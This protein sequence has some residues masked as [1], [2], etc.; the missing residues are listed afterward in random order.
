[1]GKKSK[2]ILHVPIDNFKLHQAM[3]ETCRAC[4]RTHPSDRILFH[5]FQN[6]ARTYFELTSIQLHEYETSDLLKLCHDCVDKLA[7]FERF[8]DVCYRVHWDLLRVKVEPAEYSDS[9]TLNEDYQ[10][11][12]DSADGQDPAEIPCTTMLFAT[13]NE[14][15]KGESPSEEEGIRKPKKA[16]TKYGSYKKSVKTVPFSCDRCSEVFQDRSLLIA[17]VRGH[18]GL[19]PYHCEI[20]EQDFTSLLDMKMHHAEKH[21]QR[22]SLS[23]DHPGCGEF[24]EN[25]QALRYHKTRIHDP[26]YVGPKPRVYMCENCG[27]SFNTK[28]RLTRHK[29][30]THE[31]EEKNHICEICSMRFAKPYKLKRHMLRHDGIRRYVCPYCGVAKLTKGEV[32]SHMSNKHKSKPPLINGVYEV[33]F[34]GDEGLMSSEDATSS[35]QT[36]SRKRKQEE[37]WVCNVRKHNRNFGK[38]YVRKD[39]V[40]VEGKA[41]PR[42]FECGCPRLCWTKFGSDAILEQFFDSFWNLGDWHKQNTLLSEQVKG[43]EVNRHRPRGECNIRPERT[44]SFQYFIPSEQENVRVCQKYFLGILQISAGRLYKCLGRKG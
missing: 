10:G 24:F 5:D 42:Q 22:R 17:H 18:A 12:E 8:R 27:E 36:A 1:M 14:S 28:Q 23:C 29:F 39:N 38:A 11:A 7:D 35:R 41:F 34:C 19:V 3:Y 20:C 15:A 40:L 9:Q 31:Q 43:V 6:H 32:V 25:Y 33:T 2:F 37:E 44:V 21:T 16:R 13:S 4:G 30:S 26:N